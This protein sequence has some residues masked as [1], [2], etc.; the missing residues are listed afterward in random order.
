[1]TEYNLQTKDELLYT[2]AVRET[3]RYQL[4]PSSQFPVK[5]KDVQSTTQ[6]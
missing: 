5:P 2:K 1:M 4:K 3:K 6:D